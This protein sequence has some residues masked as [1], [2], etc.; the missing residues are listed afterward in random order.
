MVSAQR[1]IAVVGPDSWVTM[2]WNQ[3]GVSGPTS[4]ATPGIQPLAVS[5]SLAGRRSLKRSMGFVLM[6]GSGMTMPA[7]P[8]PA[9]PRLPVMASMR[10]AQA[11][12]QG[13]SADWS[14]MPLPML[15]PIGLVVPM[16]RATS[17]MRSSGMP[18]MG[19]AQEGGNCLTCSAS[20]SKPRHQFSTKS[21]S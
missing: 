20:S 18:V 15:M 12:V 5:S 3:R 6:S 21:W 14:P 2:S 10:Q 8:P 16:R 7:P 19:A 9:M 11:T 4:L 13:P 1:L 17:M